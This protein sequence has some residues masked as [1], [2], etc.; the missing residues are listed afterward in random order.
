MWIDSRLS[1]NMWINYC[2]LAR[3]HTRQTNHVLQSAFEL[4]EVTRTWPTSRISS[5]EA[6]RTSPGLLEITCPS[7]NTSSKGAIYIYLIYDQWLKM[8]VV[9][10]II[11]I[12]SS[13]RSTSLDVSIMAFARDR[14]QAASSKKKQCMHDSKPGNTYIILL[15]KMLAS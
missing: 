5:W 11:S 9:L 1:V 14:T 2:G 12:P 10:P 4:I 15:T 3:M 7:V 13:P 6:I 8:Q